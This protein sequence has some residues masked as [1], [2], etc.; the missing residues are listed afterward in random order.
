MKTNPLEQLKIA[1]TSQEL[2]QVLEQFYNSTSHLVFNY[3]KKKGLAQ[4]IREDIVQIV[5]TQIF[6]KRSQYNP[7]HSPLAWLYT[8][9]RSETKDYLKA[10]STYISYIHDFSEFLSQ[11]A[12]SNPSSSEQVDVDSLLN[13]LSANERAALLK[14]YHEDKEFEEIA[15]EMK[16]TAVNIRKLISRGLQKMKKGVSS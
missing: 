1:Q 15:K 13:Q 14:R 12:D 6:K 9:T 4:E 7:A 5:Y 2:S 3:C 10:Q 8:I 11:N 16:L